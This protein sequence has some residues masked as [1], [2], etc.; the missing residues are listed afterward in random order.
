[1]RH[2]I[3]FFSVTFG[4]CGITDQ[5]CDF[6]NVMRRELGDWFRQESVTSTWIR[7]TSPK[8]NCSTSYV[9]PKDADAATTAN[10]A[11]IATS[12]AKTSGHCGTEWPAFKT[13]HAG[14]PDHGSN[15]A[16]PS[17][18]AFAVEALCYVDGKCSSAFEIMGSFSQATHEGPFGQAHEVP[19]LKE[20][21]FTPFN[22]EPS[23]KPI[24]GD[25]RYVAIE[26]GSF[27]D[28]IVRG[29]F[30]YHAPLQWGGAGAG[31][32]TQEHAHGGAAQP[33]G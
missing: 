18:S 9:I 11:A 16:Y 17:W 15:G 21:P 31:S 25:T 7:A 33:G 2:V 14:R 6:T 20:A 8:C 3:D 22:N 5:P 12:L 30:G 1:M 26:G 29:F 28:A 23:F 32:S 19:Q 10:I 4:L 27:F 13:C 24:A